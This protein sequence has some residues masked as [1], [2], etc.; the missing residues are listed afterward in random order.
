MQPLPCITMFLLIARESVLSSLAKE[1]ASYDD[2]LDRRKGEK[3][4]RKKKGGGDSLCVCKKY[5]LN[6]K[7]GK[8]VSRKKN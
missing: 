7:Q 3:Q 8:M 5:I 6:I 1:L 2:M 4:K